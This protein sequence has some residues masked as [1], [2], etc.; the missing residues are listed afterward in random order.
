MADR[1]FSL[2]PYGQAKPFQYV[3]ITPNLL[4]QSLFR[5]HGHMQCVI[6]QKA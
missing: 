3:V 2:Q 4:N 6:R 5:L 1:V